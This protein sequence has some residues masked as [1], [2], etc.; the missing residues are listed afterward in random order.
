[1]GDPLNQK[2]V[3]QKPVEASVFRNNNKKV[4]DMAR[5]GPIIITRN[6]DT[7]VLMSYQKFF[8]LSNDQYLIPRGIPRGIVRTVVHFTQTDV[9]PPA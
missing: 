2:V 1:M 3:Q 5:R 6:K 4:Y 8:N 7:F 9:N